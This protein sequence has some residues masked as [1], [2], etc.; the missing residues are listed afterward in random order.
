VVKDAMAAINYEGISGVITYDEQHNPIKKAAV[1][2]VEGG[3]VVFYKFV[4]P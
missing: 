2:K 4:A 3:Q 1:M